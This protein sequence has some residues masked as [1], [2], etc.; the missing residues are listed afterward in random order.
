MYENMY[1]LCMTHFHCWIT[2]LKCITSEKQRT[3]P[4]KEDS[5]VKGGLADM[6]MIQELWM[7]TFSS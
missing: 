5:I 2:N 6:D 3:S 7:N 4:W 1:Y